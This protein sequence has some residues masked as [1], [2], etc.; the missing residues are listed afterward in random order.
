MLRI[1]LLPPYIYDRQKKVKWVVASLAIPAVTLV[2]LLWMLA[3]AQAA[4]TTAN[5]RK[6]EAQT[7]KDQYDKLDQQIKKE[8]ELVAATKAKQDFVASAIKYNESWPQVYTEM[9][10]VTSPRVL[11]KSMYVSDDHKS[12]NFTGF[13]ANEEDLVRWWMYLR[14]QSALYTEVH[15]Q[16]PDHPWPPK[17]EAGA[18]A[19]PG[20]M[21]APGM[22]GGSG[23]MPPMAGMGAM[24]MGPPSS[25]GGMGPGRPMG[26]GAMGGSGGM[27]GSFGG[28]GSSDTVGPTE[29]E[30]RKGINFSAYAVLKQP[31][32]GGIPTPAWGGGGAAAAPGGGGPMMGPGS[33]PGGM[34]PGTIPGGSGMGK[35][36]AAM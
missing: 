36:N 21:T 32:A 11:L 35:K 23:G 25:A 9:R 22:S 27:P 17:A 2:L 30:G 33:M 20:G 24:A 13:C 12:I 10:D 28:G 4:Y 7:Q 1:N 16:L 3:Q 26:M 31:L 14:G 18:G 6:T 29:I 8:H 5:N 34:G 15:F 19:G